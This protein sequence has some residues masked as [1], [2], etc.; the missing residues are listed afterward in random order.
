MFTPVLF[1]TLCTFFL[2]DCF[3]VSVFGI[4]S[5][6]ESSRRKGWNWKFD[7]D[8]SAVAVETEISLMDILSPKDVKPGLDI[9]S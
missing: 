1:L 9:A 4:L 7:Q 5:G 8:V 2:A 3:S 6:F